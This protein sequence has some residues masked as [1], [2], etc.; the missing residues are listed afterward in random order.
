[1]P[2]PLPASSDNSGRGF[3]VA[4]GSYSEATRRQNEW[5]AKNG[6]T[7]ITFDALEIASGTEV[8]IPVEVCR[9]LRA[10]RI[11]LLQLSRNRQDVHAF[12]QAKGGTEVEAGERIAAGL[13]RIVQ[14][15]V[16][17]APPKGLVLA[18]GETASTIARAL[19]F[20][21]LRVG[22]NIEPGIPLCVTISP[23]S[24]PVVFKS[25]NFGSDDFYGR[26]INAISSLRSC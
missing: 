4:A 7:V 22:T 13:A 18:G 23:S 10:D 16:S 21:A 3:L 19:Q 24:L 25:G 6:A 26:A 2:G 8:E 14:E 9:A 1:V 11:C 15:I 12:F 17:A 20:R 5:L